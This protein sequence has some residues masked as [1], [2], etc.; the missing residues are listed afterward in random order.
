[1]IGLDA[2]VGYEKK[3]PTM[4]VVSIMDLIKVT[5]KVF[6]KSDPSVTTK[7]LKKEFWRVLNKEATV[8]T[9]EETL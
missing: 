1:M 5:D 7:L 9:M 6:P 8:H 4:R 2:D 3:A